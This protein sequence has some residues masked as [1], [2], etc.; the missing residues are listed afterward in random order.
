M[1]PTEQVNQARRHCLLKLLPAGTRV[2]P[3]GPDRY[4]V[5]CPFHDDGTPSMSITEYPDGTWRYMCFGCGERG[6]PIQ[7]LIKSE[8][9]TFMDAVRRLTD[10]AKTA[11]EQ[12]KEVAHYDYRDEAGQLLYQVVRYDPKGFRQRVPLPDRGHGDQTKWCWSLQGVKRVLYRLPELLGLRYGSRV[13]FVEGEKDVE[14]IRE[15]GF[16]ATTSGSS[17]SWR[18]E[19]AQYFDGME[20]VVVPDNDEPGKKFM[21]QVYREVKSCAVRVGFVLL[22]DGAKDVSDYLVKHTMKEL[23]G[24]VKWV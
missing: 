21:R 9:E 8:G 7:Y 20:V 22:P 4:K 12:R 23:E 2:R 5:N 14:T 19:F 18:P 13:W 16:N 24:L 10:A 15:R 3:S 6:D 11:P 1:I 17:T